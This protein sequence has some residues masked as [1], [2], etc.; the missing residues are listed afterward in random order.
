MP[1]IVHLRFRTETACRD[2]EA[3]SLGNVLTVAETDRFLQA[4]GMIRLVMEGNKVRF[5]I[6]DAAAKSA[7]YA[8]ARNC[9]NVPGR[10]R[11]PA[12]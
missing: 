5:D 9:L 3:A 10:R 8:S 2:I 1:D 7:A 12:K 4:G 11:Q 6:N